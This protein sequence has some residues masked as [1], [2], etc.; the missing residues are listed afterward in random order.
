MVS[1]VKTKWHIFI[2]LKKIA[3]AHISYHDVQTDFIRKKSRKVKKQ[4]MCAFN[5]Q[6]QNCVVRYYLLTYISA[7]QSQ[8]TKLMNEISN[9][10][11]ID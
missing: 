3:N 4:I 7:Y 8:L 1:K 5:K 6:R 10:I 11:N 2:H 9:L